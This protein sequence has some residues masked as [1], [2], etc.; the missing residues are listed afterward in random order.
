MIEFVSFWDQY[1]VVSSKQGH[2]YAFEEAFQTVQVLE[3]T[4]H[5][6]IQILLHKHVQTQRWI[7]SSTSNQD[8]PFATRLNLHF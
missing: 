8:I 1:Q 4:L 7:D 3:E 2:S 6:V 5:Q